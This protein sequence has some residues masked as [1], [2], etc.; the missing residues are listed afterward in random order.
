M[1]KKNKPARLSDV[2]ARSYFTKYQNETK[3][4]KKIKKRIQNTK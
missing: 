1:K 3:C 4:Q 2:H